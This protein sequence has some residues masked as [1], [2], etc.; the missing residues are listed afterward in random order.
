MIRFMKYAGT[1]FFMLDIYK[2]LESQITAKVYCEPFIGGGSIFFNT[3]EFDKYIINDINPYLIKIYESFKEVDSFELYK[4]LILRV[5]EEFGDIKKNKKDYYE[6]RSYVNSLKNKET[7]QVEYGIYLHLL[8]NSC[9]NSMFRTGPNGFN[10]GWGNRFYYL[11]DKE[12]FNII[13]K[14]LSKTEI[15]NV[16]YHE[17]LQND[18]NI[19]YFL[20]PPY[21][22]GRKKAGYDGFDSKRFLEF[23]EIIKNLE[24]EFLY[25][26]TIKDENS[27]LN[28]ISIRKYQTIAPSKRK[29][30]E[31]TLSDERLFMSSNFIME[32]ELKPVQLF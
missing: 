5:F 29:N 25:T 19:F 11:Q 24:S 1:K 26:D 21:L 9:I 28:N 32:P 30:S 3:K 12:E 22:E 31:E 7:K 13:K 2:K 15:Y 17:L 23:I 18:K 10:Q 8:A 16:P 27:F 4:D 14:R 20:D 6:F